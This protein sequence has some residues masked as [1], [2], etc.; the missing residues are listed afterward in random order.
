M[1]ERASSF[2][3]QQALE[4][5]SGA[6]S[7]KSTCPTRFLQRV[8]LRKCKPVLG[9]AIEGGA[10]VGGQSTPRVVCVHVSIAHRQRFG[11]PP[12]GRDFRALSG[13]L[14]AARSLSWAQL[15]CPS[16][17]YQLSG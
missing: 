11:T 16:K 4:G 12:A 5:H 1:T 7:R 14:F 6:N 10:N 2:V 17:G 3:R 8:R 13:Y 9:I 15:S